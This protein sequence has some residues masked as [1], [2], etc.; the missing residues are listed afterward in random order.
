VATLVLKSCSIWAIATLIA[1]KSFASTNTATA[2]AASA[3][4]VPRSIGFAAPSTA[5]AP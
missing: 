5:G 3:S 1:E 4:R 2:I